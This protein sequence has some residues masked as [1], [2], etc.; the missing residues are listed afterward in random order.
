MNAPDPE[1]IQAITKRKSL[2]W[3]LLPWGISCPAVTRIVGTGN[4]K[5]RQ[6][7]C[8]FAQ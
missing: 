5:A 2:V 6:A 8:L 7:N 4:D 3:V 1:Q